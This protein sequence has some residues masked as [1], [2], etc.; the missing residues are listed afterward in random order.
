METL[1]RI[2]KLVQRTTWRRRGRYIRDLLGFLR[3]VVENR[4]EWGYHMGCYW[5]TILCIITWVSEK[6]GNFQDLYFN[7]TM[8]THQWT[9]WTERV[10]YFQPWLMGKWKRE[11]LCN[12]GETGGSRNCSHKPTL[13]IYGDM[14]LVLDS[15]NVENDQNCYLWFQSF[16]HCWFVGL[17]WPFPQGGYF[18][19]DGEP[20]NHFMVFLGGGR[21]TTGKHWPWSTESFFIVQGYIV[22]S[23]KNDKRQLI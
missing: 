18:N 6:M 16:P 5:P 21:L 7:W 10:D 23:S 20:K 12:W 2:A 19:Q 11:P 3:M 22:Q 14:S 9:E 15:D 13:W 17:S 8:M 4:A 1:K